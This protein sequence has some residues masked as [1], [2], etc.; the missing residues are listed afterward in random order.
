MGEGEVLPISGRDIFDEQCKGSSF[1]SLLSLTNIRSVGL[2]HRPVSASR[3][4]RPDNH[5]HQCLKY[6]YLASL[7]VQVPAGQ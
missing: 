6:N 7:A 1:N 4:S 2:R 5:R 3:R